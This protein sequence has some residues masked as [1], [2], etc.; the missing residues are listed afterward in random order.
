MVY[1]VKN[2]TLYNSTINLD[3]IYENLG[4]DSVKYIKNSHF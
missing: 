1:N 4:E 3:K 2:I